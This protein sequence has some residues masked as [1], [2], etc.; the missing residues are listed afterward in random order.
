M[1]WGLFLEDIIREHLEASQTTVDISQILYKPGCH[2]ISLSLHTLQPMGLF[3]KLAPLL[4]LIFY[5]YAYDYVIVGGG[6][7]WVCLRSRNSQSMGTDWDS[8]EAWLWLVDYQRIRPW[9][10]LSLKLDPTRK[11]SPRY[12]PLVAQWICSVTDSLEGFCSR[13]DWDGSKFY[14]T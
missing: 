4:F 3:S 5:V 8:E 6:T 14:D 2:F 1:R 9:Q 12:E 11:I 10:L 13:F 7:A